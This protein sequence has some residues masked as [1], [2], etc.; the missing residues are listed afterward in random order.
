M[1]VELRLGGLIT[2]GGREI[3]LGQTYALLDAIAQERSVNG[4]A[5]RLRISYRSAWG[6]IVALE[7]ALGRPVAVKTK[8]H[9]SILTEFGAGLRDALGATVTSFE[10]LVEQQ[11]RVLHDR[12]TALTGEPRRPLR[13]AMSHDPLLMS[14]LSGMPT[15]A[16]SVV[17]SSEAVELLLGGRADAAGFH[18]GDLEPGSS[19][20][21]DR[22]FQDTALVVTPLF[23]REQGLMVASGNPL[24]IESVTDL[25]RT[26]ARFVNRQ[27][28]S[29]TR[30][31][32]D[33]L[34]REAKIP[35]GSIV[36]YDV[37]E[38]THQAVAAVIAAGAADAG[39][40][41][42]SVAER[43]GLDFTP[44]GREAY[45][46]AGPRDAVDDVSVMLLPP[47]RQ[48]IRTTAGYGNPDRRHRL[49]DG[50]GGPPAARAVTSKARRARDGR[51]STGS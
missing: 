17:G 34:L 47:L 13:L 37:E 7:E 18:M 49:P 24:A 22:L 20:H 12:L 46:L 10:T 50:T 11:E 28:G 45:Y 19:P 29:G 44:V 26:K 4:A 3:A 51:G 39:M 30:A 38:F 32:F 43:F 25:A 9:G 36:G 21:F 15:I 23:M 5:M 16:P 48:R 42:R 33:R 41:V 40:G 8:G 14:V 2:V 1:R 35:S 6:R 27:R 31:W